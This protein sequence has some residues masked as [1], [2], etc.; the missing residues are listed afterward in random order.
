MSIIADRHSK[1]KLLHFGDCLWM[2]SELLCDFTT[3]GK[4]CDT[5][6]FLDLFAVWGGGGDDILNER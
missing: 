4:L 6:L 3:I 5:S 1:Y 2:I